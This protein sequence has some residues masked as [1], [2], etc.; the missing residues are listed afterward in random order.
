MNNKR[1]SAEIITAVIGIIIIVVI[2]VV[3]INFGYGNEQNIEITVKDKY[4]KRYSKSDTYMVVD[5]NGNTYKITDM[6]FL[7]KFDSTDLYNQLEIGN[8]YKIKTTGYRNNFL[9][10]YPNINKIEN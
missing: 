9:S 10:E 3:S 8:T 1:G 5:T 2:A 6:L 7:G 4:I